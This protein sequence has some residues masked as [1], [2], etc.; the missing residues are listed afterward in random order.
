MKVG[1]FDSGIGGLSVLRELK[2]LLPDCDFLFYGDNKNNPYGEKSDE[3]LMAIVSQVVEYLRDQGCEVIVIACN[4]ATTRCRNKLIAQYPELTFIGTVPAVKVASDRNY[5]RTLVMA[6]PAT[7]RSER[8]YELIRD[9]K[10]EDQIIYTIPCRGLANAIET[11]Q[12]KRIDMI[13][14]RIFRWYLNKDIDSIV[15]GCTHYPFIRDKIQAYFP[16]AALLD[17]ANGVARETRHQL[18][19]KGYQPQ[20]RE[21]T[22]TYLTSNDQPIPEDLKV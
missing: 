14:K 19:L 18:I 7:I 5:K 2:R 21:G 1:V 4:T 12:E 6:T 3:E 15:L 22:I 16:K 13:L 17:G 10:K 8:M 11:R 20:D 9:N